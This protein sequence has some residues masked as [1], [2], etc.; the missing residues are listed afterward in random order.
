MTYNIVLMGGGRELKIMMVG[1]VRGGHHTLTKQMSGKTKENIPL[2]LGVGSVH[3]GF[4]QP[5]LLIQ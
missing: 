1:I 3:L 2:V 5:N 4:M